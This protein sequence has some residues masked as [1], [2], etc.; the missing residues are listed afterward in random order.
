MTTT[1]ANPSAQAY[2][3]LVAD[4]YERDFTAT[5]IGQMLRRAVWRELERVFRQGER[6][7]ELNCGTGIDAVH[8][9]ERGM[10]ILACDIS[11][12]MI[13]LARQRAN[14]TKFGDRIDCRVLATENLGLLVESC[15]FD[16]A[17]SNFSGLI[18]V[19]DLDLVRKNLARLLK[20]GAPLVLC[21]LGQFVPWEIAWFLAHGDR[22]TAMR[23]L[24]L[25]GCHRSEPGAPKVSYSSRREIVRAFEPDFRLRRWRG[26]GIFLP[27]SYMGH[28]AQHFPRVAEALDRADRLLGSICLIRSMANFM[29][30]EFQQ[31]KR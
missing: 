29:L 27:P 3:N 16:G 30:L 7:L 9:A 15:T 20:P 1:N 26:L 18:C 19:E 21:M 14:T 10:R 23:R 5:L 31:A 24:Q 17:F 12:R 22:N 6:I 2:W 8:L 13:D 25:N 28:W 4:R 11:G